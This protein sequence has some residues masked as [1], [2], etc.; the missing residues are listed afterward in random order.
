MAQGAARSQAAAATLRLTW[1]PVTAAG[2]QSHV[3]GKL[4]VRRLVTALL[5]GARVFTFESTYLARRGARGAAGCG[6]AGAGSPALVCTGHS[7]AQVEVNALSSRL[8]TA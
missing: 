3:H 6:A 1:L 8:W 7:K 4:Q 2:A 5:C